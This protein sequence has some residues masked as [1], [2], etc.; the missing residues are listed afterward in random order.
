M[1]EEDG[2]EVLLL[3]LCRGCAI[4]PIPIPPHSP[5]VHTLRRGS[6]TGA[7]SFV[8]RLFVPNALV[9][10][11]STADPLGAR[12]PLVHPFDATLL[13]Y[14]I[15][16]ADHSLLRVASPLDGGL[17]VGSDRQVPDGVLRRALHVSR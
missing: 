6:S 16:C 11:A 7:S 9:I 17:C 12:L 13:K 8:G 4:R 14:V 5:R 15:R 3:L 2:I 1:T 10:R